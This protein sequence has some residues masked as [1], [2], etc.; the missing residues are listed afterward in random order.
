MKHKQ[1]RHKQATVY[2]AAFWFGVSHFVR[3]WG[4]RADV[5]VS[6][7]LRELVSRRKRSYLNDMKMMPDGLITAGNRLVRVCQRDPPV[8]RV[9]TW[10]QSD[11][12]YPGIDRCLGYKIP[13]PWYWP[14]L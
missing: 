7:H 4:V 9:T 12:A 8:D 10:A 13:N 1:S 5:T 2:L 6:S 3:G 11:P 14:D